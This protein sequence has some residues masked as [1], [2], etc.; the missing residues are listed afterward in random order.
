MEVQDLSIAV[1][2]DIHEVPIVDETV[3]QS[4]PLQHHERE[5]TA[6]TWIL[7]QEKLLFI[8]RLVC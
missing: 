4:R 6:W 8:G 7:G 2:L 3:L 5:Q 1:R